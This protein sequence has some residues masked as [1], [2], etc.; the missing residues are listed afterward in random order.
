[1][2]VS[3]LTE[4]ALSDFKTFQRELKNGPGTRRKTLNILK[5]YLN[6]AT[7][8][9]VITRHANLFTCRNL[10]KPAPNK[11]WLTE[12]E[13]LALVITSLPPH[14]AHTAYFLPFYLHDSRVG[15]VLHL[16]WK[17]RAHGTVRF[18]MNKGDREKIVEESPQFTALLGSLRPEA[19]KPDPEVY[20]LPWLYKSYKQVSPIK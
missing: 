18:K 17:Q 11:A 8:R 15:V 5:I 10:P 4:T 14:L 20:E 7:E 19:G 1:M 3:Q 12:A 16:K 13:L 2:P 9:G 6:Q